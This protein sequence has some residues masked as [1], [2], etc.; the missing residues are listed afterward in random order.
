VRRFISSSLFTN[1]AGCE[2]GLAEQAHAYIAHAYQSAI[3]AQRPL[4]V[5]NHGE[6]V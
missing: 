3:V 2:I 1:T 4:R 5:N 6:G